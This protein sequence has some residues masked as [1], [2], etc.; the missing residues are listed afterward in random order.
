MRAV[1]KSY[2]HHIHL[3]LDPQS[4]QIHDIGYCTPHPT[5]PVRFVKR[6][7]RYLIQTYKKNDSLN[8]IRHNVMHK[9]IKQILIKLRQRDV[10]ETRNA[11]EIVD[12]K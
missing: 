3:E 8:A 7:Q 10:T 9:V 4:F 2:K 6:A 5:P 12:N 1:S 11:A